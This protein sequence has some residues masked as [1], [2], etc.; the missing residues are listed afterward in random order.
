MGAGHQRPG[1]DGGF[2][3]I[4]DRFPHARAGPGGSTELLAA[5]G[6]GRNAQPWEQAM[7]LLVDLVGS[8]DL[9]T[10][11]RMDVGNRDWTLLALHLELFGGS[12]DATST[13]P[14]CVQ[15]VE[16]RLSVETFLELTTNDRPDDGWLTLVYGPHEYRLRLPTSEDLAAVV[17]LD[18]VEAR[19]V[20]LSRCVPDIGES[21]TRDP[22]LEAAVV[23][24]MAQADPC[25]DIVL[26][27]LCPVC[28]DS[29]RVSF[30]I[31][32]FLWRELDAW[33]HRVLGDV[34]RLA[35]AYG[36]SEREILDLPPWRR[37]YY[38][39]SLGA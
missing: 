17:G 2:L 38:A 32:V 27:L 31:T 10:F 37:Q 29:W 30:D 15:E 21:A 11:T 6:R 34:Q 16:A 25:A 8:E 39:E 26:A 23:E 7:V 19:Q 35:G 1:A 3:L 28:D 5:W 9:S 20:L 13:C 22:A 36:W 24:R 14:S 12:L 18:P 4:M 33:A